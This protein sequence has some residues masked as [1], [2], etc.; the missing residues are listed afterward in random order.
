MEGIDLTKFQ[1]DEK[2]KEKIRAI[3]GK[4]LS[5]RAGY[6]AILEER[7][8]GVQKRCVKCNWGIEP[9]TKFCPECGSKQ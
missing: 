1:N 9:G 5:G 7:K 6:E 4:V 3:M 2:E 8:E